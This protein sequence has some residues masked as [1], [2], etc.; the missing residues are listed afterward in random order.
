MI[1]PPEPL[2]AEHDL[3][4]FDCGKPALNEWLR[5]YA[6]ANQ[7]NGFTRVMVLRN[8][9]RVIGFY[10]L[11]PTAVPPAI[12]SRKVRTGRP[13]DPVP[14]I[15]FGQLAVDTAHAGQGLGSALLRHALERC[16]AA[17]ETIGGRA[18]IVRA[19][20]GEAEEFWKSCGFI[21]SS[22]DSSTLFRSIDDIAAWLAQSRQSE[23][24][25]NDG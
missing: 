16:V 10:G 13:P 4:A 3:S 24:E 21:P 5:T 2:N 6:L 23:G 11:A 25:Q 20:D 9:A 15:L 7:A 12:L 8:G 19:I 14:C 1:R 22:S 18:V 17:V